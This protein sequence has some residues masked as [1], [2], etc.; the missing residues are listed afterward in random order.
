MAIPC[1]HHFSSIDHRYVRVHVSRVDFSLYVTDG[2][3]YRWYRG[4]NKTVCVPDEQDL[5][6]KT[7]T[8][9]CIV[10]L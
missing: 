4:S 8:S 6:R 3:D 7:L 9:V 2:R 1:S 5:K 10:R